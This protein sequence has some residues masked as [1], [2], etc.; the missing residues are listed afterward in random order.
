VPSTVE[1]D[2]TA[3]ERTKQIA[4]ERP[5][6]IEMGVA[7]SAMM[8]ARSSTPTYGNQ[9]YTLWQQLMDASVSCY[10]SYGCK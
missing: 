1:K 3:E 7:C 4:L 10:P 8:V 6:E 9:I 2:K 5:E